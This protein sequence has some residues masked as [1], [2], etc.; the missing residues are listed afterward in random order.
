MMIERRQGVAPLQR[1][2]LTNAEILSHL[3]AME[4]SRNQDCPH[5][6]GQFAPDPLPFHHGLVR[7]H[8]FA[9]LTDDHLVRFPEALAS[10]TA[11]L[12]DM[13]ASGASASSSDMRVNRIRSDFPPVPPG[14]FFVQ[15]AA[16]NE[17][18]NSFQPEVRGKPQTRERNKHAAS[19][20]E[21]S[22]MPRQ[23]R[24]PVHE[25]DAAPRHAASRRSCG[26]TDDTLDMLLS[27]AFDVLGILSAP[28]L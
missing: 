28:Y 23:E 16:G 27:F 24:A 1:S 18:P 17:V 3:I 7:R 25:L 11:A 20:S 5:P 15:T 9:Y 22:L 13:R 19:G 21:A 8:S 4:R 2:R 6:Q 26:M 12:R 14:V 10:Q